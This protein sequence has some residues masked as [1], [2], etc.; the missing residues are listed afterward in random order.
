[1][2]LL[3][4]KDIELFVER[5]KA[6]VAEADRARTISALLAKAV[7]ALGNSGEPRREKAA[8]GKHKGKSRRKVDLVEDRLLDVLRSRLGERGMS[9][10]ALSKALDG[11]GP[12]QVRYVLNKLRER[13]LVRMTGDRSTALWHTTSR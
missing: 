10:G 2:E 5:L 1:M 12:H 8:K 4:E 9:I 11:K 6:T 13:K 3:T 7:S